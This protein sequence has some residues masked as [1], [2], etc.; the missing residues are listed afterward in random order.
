MTKKQDHEG[1]KRCP[2]LSVRL[3]P[4]ERQMLLDAA[5]KMPLSDY[6]RARLFGGS[7]DSKSETSANMPV[8]LS[9]K[10]RQRLLAQIL[11]KLGETSALLSLTEISEAARLGLL[12]MSPDV[13]ARLNEACADI[14][15]IRLML[16]KSLG[17]SPRSN[18]GDED[19]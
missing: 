8:R 10:E 2:L 16:V 17:K 6:V 5:G 15:V 1:T 18:K 14:N 11:A 7:E 13:L 9:A 12:T 4:E 3:T 19:K